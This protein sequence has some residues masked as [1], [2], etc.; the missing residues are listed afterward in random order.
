MPFETI[1]HS[2]SHNTH[3]DNSP[4][5]HMLPKDI[6]NCRQRLL[7]HPLYDS[8][9]DVNGLRIFMQHH[10]FAVLDFMSLVKALQRRLTSVD[11]IWRPAGQPKLRRFINDIVLAEESDPDLHGGYLSHFELYLEAMRE[12]GADTRAIQAVTRALTA[13]SPWRLA[14]TAPSIPESA[15]E[16]VGHTFELVETG[17]TLE[18]AAAF[19][20]GR[21]GLIPEMFSAIVQSITHDAKLHTPTL[22]YYLERHI[23]IDGDEHG[24]MA[25]QLMHSLCA[26][27][28]ARQRLAHAAGLSALQARLRFWDHIHQAIQQNDQ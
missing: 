13:G 23:A 16:F 25:E 1:S 21:E 6:P 11:L 24:P 10:V 15:R 17:S 14:M 18:I 9:R 19:C 3:S 20:H 8:L 12:I 28:P 22:T 7:E 4:S 27:E 26:D 5:D 2:P